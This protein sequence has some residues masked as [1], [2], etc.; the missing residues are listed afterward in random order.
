[1]AALEDS[2][3]ELASLEANLPSHPVENTPA[4]FLSLNGQ[5]DPERAKAVVPAHRLPVEL[6]ADIFSLT[7]RD[8]EPGHFQDAYRVCHV[9]S[10]WEQIAVTTPQLWTGTVS[11]T[12][13]K[14]LSAKTVDGLRAWL[15]RS[16]PLSIPVFLKGPI[17]HDA[18]DTGVFPPV[19]EA[20]LQVAPRW[21]RLRVDGS[22]TLPGFYER[23]AEYSLD[24]LEEADLSLNSVP[25]LSAAPR[26]RELRVVAD[27]LLRMPWEQLTRLDLLETSSECLGLIAQCPN[28]LELTVFTDDTYQHDIGTIVAN[29]PRL[30]TLHVHSLSDSSDPEQLDQ[31]LNILHAPALDVL[32]IYAETTWTPAVLAAFQLRSPHITDLR[33]E[34]CPPISN[35]LEA[36]LR[37]APL[38][39]RLSLRYCDVGS[40]ELIAALAH[41]PSLTYLMLENCFGVDDA[42][43]LALHYTD[44]SPPLVPRLHDFSL[45]GMQQLDVTEDCILAMLLSRCR[46]DDGMT[47]TPREV[48]RWSRLVLERP[49]NWTQ[50]PSFNMHFREELERRGFYVKTGDCWRITAT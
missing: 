9:C 2:E 29:L 38:L 25:F 44:N 1:M 7:I 21:R 18:D 28:L 3:R 12:V 22:L 4:S 37:H 35:K 23:L 24:S 11:V 45:F 17:W 13:T 15:A 20:L 16:A 32:E 40:N 39:T 33:L 49:Y 50:R 47:S 19:L 26:L 43:M 31:L 30:Q 8:K 41:A 34:N 36:A 10:Q 48:A 6:L 14:T 5:R 27:P 46:A 42:F